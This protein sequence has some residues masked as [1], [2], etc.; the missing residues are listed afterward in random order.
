MMMWSVL[1]SKSAFVFISYSEKNQT[2]NW[3][4]IL[5][6]LISI[7]NLKKSFLKIKN[8]KLDKI[9]CGI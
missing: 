2:N 4:L 3:V 6:K 7:F 9:K 8:E 5:K 1:T